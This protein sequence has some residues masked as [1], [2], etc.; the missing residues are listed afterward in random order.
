[1]LHAALHAKALCHCLGEQSAALQ[2][3]EKSN[4]ALP[5]TKIMNRSLIKA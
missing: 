5:K 2:S 4:T 3:S 1:M